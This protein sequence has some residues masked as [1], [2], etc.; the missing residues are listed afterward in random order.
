MRNSRLIFRVVLWVHLRPVMGSP[1]Q[2]VT[3]CAGPPNAIDLHVAL[4]QLGS[5]LRNGMD[6]HS[7]QLGNSAVAA[8]SKAQGFQP[9][10]EPAL[11]L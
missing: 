1:H 8:M 4:E 10:V 7:G 5:S 2:R 6:I 9:R 11:S 3:P